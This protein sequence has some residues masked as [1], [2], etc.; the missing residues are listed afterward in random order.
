MPIL[1]KKIEFYKGESDHEAIAITAVGLGEEGCYK[2]P[3]AAG[4]SHYEGPFLP[5]NFF[6]LPMKVLASPIVT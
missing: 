6:P 2:P 1:Y 3:L 4:F 5:P